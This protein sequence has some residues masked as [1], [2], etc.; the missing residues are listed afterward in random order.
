M[1]NRKSHADERS[2]CDGEVAWFWHPGADA[3]Q[4]DDEFAGDGGKT[5]GPR[6][7]RV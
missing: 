2:R 7:E 4:A 6:E 3:K 1:L 5:A